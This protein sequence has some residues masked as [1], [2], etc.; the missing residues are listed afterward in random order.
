MKTKL[1]VSNSQLGWALFMKTFFYGLW[2]I[3]LAWLIL[4]GSVLTVGAVVILAGMIN[5]VAGIVLDMV[6]WLV[7]PIILAVWVVDD[8]KKFRDRGIGVTPGLW[9]LSVFFLGGIFFPVYLI[10]RQ[11]VW[12]KRSEGSEEPGEHRQLRLL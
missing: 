11:I 5:P 10:Y 12:P 2:L 6:L 1:P 4:F 8:A 3:I 9:G 7:V